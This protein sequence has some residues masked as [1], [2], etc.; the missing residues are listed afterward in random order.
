MERPKG[1]LISY[2]SNI[3]KQNGGINLAQGIPGFPPPPQLL[4]ILQQLSQKKDLH[5]YAPGIGNYQLLDLIRERYSAV[6]PLQENNLLIVQ[7]AT[8]GIFLTFFY[9]TTIL[10]GSYSALS[11]EPVY[12]SYP[13]LAHMFQVPFEYFDFEKDLSIDFHRLEKSIKS[14]QVKIVLLA[15]PGNPLGKIWNRNEITSLLSLSEKYGFYVIFDAVYKDIYYNAPPFNPLELHCKQLFYIDSFSKTLSIT[16]WRVGYIICDKDHMSLIR[17]LHDYTGLC[18]PS[19]LQSAIA[20]YLSS[21]E[22]GQVYTNM[23]K[24]KCKKSFRF[25]TEKLRQLSFLVHEID[26]GY[27]LWGRLPGEWK[28][29]FVFADSLYKKQKLGVVPGENFSKTKINYIRLNVASELPIIE[30]A[31]R[32]IGQFFRG[33]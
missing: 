33:M 24:T 20:Q 16:G 2:F 29:A 11:F 15:S 1:S 6:H 3:V 8:E 25:L 17:S 30:E 23:I 4:K 7:G 22:Y 12:E 31:A 21:N 18:A 32:R 14:Q 9:L 10:A 27:F 26:G 5:Q 28:D 19:I 13:Q